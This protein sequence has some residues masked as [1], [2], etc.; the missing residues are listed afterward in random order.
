[1]AY[2]LLSSYDTVR[3][4]SATS[5]TDVIYCTIATGRH[6]AIV[7]Y[8]VPK[9]SF[10]ADQGGTVLGI[11]SD[12]VDALMDA[13][14][15]LGATGEQTVDASGLIQDVVVFT[16]GYTPAN[17]TAGQ[18]TT[19]VALPVTTVVADESIA[20]LLPGGTAFDQLETEYQRL[21][22]LAGG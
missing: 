6:G 8:T 10:N 16:I 19:T 15:V 13:P 2:T 17:G 11:F 21:Q 4:L 1:M 22:A 5:A 20:G 7:Q 12:A 9:G 18:I 14:F 3:V